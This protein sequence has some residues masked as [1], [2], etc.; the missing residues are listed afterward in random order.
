MFTIGADPELFFRNQDQLISIVGKLGGSKTNPMPIGNGCAIQ[1]DNVAAEFCVP[2][3]ETAASFV[4]SINFALSDL[5]TRAESL[6]LTLAA[7]TASGEFSKD[8]LN[9]R[10][11]RTFGCDPD[12]NAYTGSANP[13][14]KADNKLLRS[15][16]GHVHVGTDKNILDVVQTLDLL[17]GVPSVIVDKD[18]ERRKLYGKAGCF[19]PKPYGVEYRTLSNF[20]IWDNRTIEWVYHQ[21]SEAIT[22]C[23]EFVK[24]VSEEDTQLIIHSINNNDKDSANFLIDKWSL[25]LP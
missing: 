4:D 8:Q 19:R 11:A 24:E 9:N 20:W 3:A 21:V 10:Q 5:K 22:F 17:L 18:E 12:F 13:R 2:P 1:E 15:A 16:G 7:L 6:G 25:E 23:S 14:P